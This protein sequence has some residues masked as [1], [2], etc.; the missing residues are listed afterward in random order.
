MNQPAPSTP[1]RRI[2]RRRAK[3]HCGAA[4]EALLRGMFAEMQRFDGFLG[5]DIVPP[6]TPDGEYQVIV[7]WASEKALA[8][9]DASPTH[10]QWLQRLAQ[11]AEGEP[12]YRLLT[13]LEA[14]FALP[15]IP[16]NAPPPRLKMA[17]VTWLGIFPTVALLQATV[18][19]W[20]AIW[21]FLLRIAAFTLLVV[22]LMTWLVMP[23]LTRWLRP[24]LTSPRPPAS[25]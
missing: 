16:G 15:A 13:G 11:V 17:L 20:L 4:Y 3:P 1:I 8:A 2:A 21:P 12:A 14:W 18:A 7:R 22:T 5:A 24:F 9:W 23:Y 10:L 19:P 25:D 6:T